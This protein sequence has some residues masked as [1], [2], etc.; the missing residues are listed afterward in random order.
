MP[1][2]V[3]PV[4]RKCPRLLRADVT[5]DEGPA[6]VRA[7]RPAAPPAITPRGV[8]GPTRA[9]FLLL[10]VDDDPLM[11]EMLPRRLRRVLDASVDIRTAATPEEARELIRALR[12]DAV[13]SD[14]NLRQIETGLDVLRDAERS[15]PDA[16]RI[17][18]SGH[19]RNEIA[20]LDTA[21]IHAYVEKPMRLDELISPILD[22]IERET[23]RDL[24]GGAPRG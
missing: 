16:T 24:R 18:F 3:L 13:L 5:D 21:P 14:Y 1:Q 7:P 2:L 4:V 10:I 12:P 11:T 6:P 9:V 8:Q 17:L 19:S 23:G 15:V 20:G 22:V